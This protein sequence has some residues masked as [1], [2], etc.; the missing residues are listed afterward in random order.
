MNTSSQKFLSRIKE[1]FDDAIFG[2]HVVDTSGKFLYLNKAE[3]NWLGYS[4]EELVGQHVSK[5]LLDSSEDAFF[6]RLKYLQENK[7]IHNLEL[8]FISKNGETVKLLANSEAVFDENEQLLFSKTFFVN[9]NQSSKIV[10][11]LLA[12]SLVQNS[13]DSIISYDLEGRIQSW[14]KRAEE[15]FS[16]SAQE[17][18]GKNVGE[19]IIDFNLEERVKQTTSGV[20]SR[21]T[22]IKNKYGAS[23]YLEILDSPIF[24]SR[25][26]IIG[27]SK[28][29]RDITE[30]VISEQMLE[31][32]NRLLLSTSKLT[33]LGEM[34]SNISHE[35]NNPLT[36]ISLKTKK[37]LKMLEANEINLEEFSEEVAKIHSTTIRIAKVVRALKDFSRDSNEEVLEKM[38]AN[39]IT[40][41]ALELCSERLNA[42][43]VTVRLIFEDVGEIECR[44]NQMVQVLLN[45]IMHSFN[46]LKNT[47]VDDRWIEINF[48]IRNDL[49]VFTIFDSMNSFKFENF[50][51]PM[52]AFYNNKTNQPQGIGLSVSQIIVEN[53]QGKMFFD[54]NGQ[55]NSVV[56]ELPMQQIIIK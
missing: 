24:D 49:A 39:Q 36:I 41:K 3:L 19:F 28:I 20:L 38:T 34:A 6:N 15:L 33:A 31:D 47:V 26:K 32:Q 53:H 10:T 13:Y 11:P 22:T 30:K 29:A 51:N 14:N 5:V 42:Y 55:M 54:K 52:S 7:V 9:L 46:R 1:N 21:K 25:S 16:T 50:N 43:G 48:K 27:Y 4:A 37:I 56:I 44:I 23:V 8:N 35:I 45:A 17:A 40:M 18:I 12:E 2:M